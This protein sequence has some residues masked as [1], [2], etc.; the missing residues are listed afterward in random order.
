M[1]QNAKSIHD[2]V[3]SLQLRDLKQQFDGK[4]LKITI[5]RANPQSLEVMHKGNEA[6]E[7]TESGKQDQQGSIQDE[8]TEIY[9]SRMF[10]SISSTSRDRERAIRAV[11]VIKPMTPCFMIILRRCHF[12][13]SSMPVPA[14][15]ATEW[16]YRSYQS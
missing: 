10:F 5:Q 1:N 9:V 11:E 12:N 6:N 14:G 4:K 15:F 13:S 16:G 3:L 2:Q 7:K 8:E